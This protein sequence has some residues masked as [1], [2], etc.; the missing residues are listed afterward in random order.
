M[1]TNIDPSLW[2]LRT[3]GGI[4][5]KMVEMDGSFSE[6][7][8]NVNWKAYIA[9]YQLPAFLAELFPPPLVIGNKPIPRVAQMP[10]APGLHA[11][12]ISFRTQTEGLPIDPFLADPSAASG[13]YNQVIEVTVGFGTGYKKPDEEDPRLFLEISSNASG[14]FYHTTCPGAKWRPQRNTAVQP[15]AP[16][17]GEAEP[18]NPVDDEEV[19]DPDTG[20]TEGKGEE[21]EDDDEPNKDPTAPVIITVPQT[22]WSVKWTQIPYELFTTVII[23]RLRLLLGRVNSTPFELLFNAYP[24]TILFEG[25]NYQTKYS[26]RDD[27][28]ETPP[29]Q[30]EMKFLEKRVFWKGYIVGHNHFWRPG[31]GWQRLLV[32]G[33]NSTYGPWNLNLMFKQ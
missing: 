6:E 4:P 1:S 25:F 13:T 7:E 8:G 27:N 10:G 28:V 17:D 11:K 32:D 19:A 3:S 18:E 29:V 21:V 26:W 16:E 12:T 20:D 2:R 23:H 24:E 14:E 9:A 5:Y 30:L 15:D 31:K 22:E 33:V